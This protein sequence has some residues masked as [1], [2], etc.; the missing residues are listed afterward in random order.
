LKNKDI[1]IIQARLSSSRVNQ[2]MINKIDDN[3]IIEWVIRRLSYINCLKIVCLPFNDIDSKLHK[4]ISKYL[5]KNLL[6]DFG[7]QENVYLRVLD[8]LSRKNIDID[9][10]LIRV[11]A[12]RPFI[13]PILVKNLSDS[14]N[15]KNSLLFNHISYKEFF[16]PRGFGAEIFSYRLFKELYSNNI[17][18]YHKE[19]MTSLIWD[20]E[21]IKKNHKFPE[22][23]IFKKYINL[24]TD[25]DVDTIEDLE[26]IKKLIVKHSLSF[27]NSFLYEKAIR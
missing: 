8:I 1:I 25:Y 7:E 23:Y 22:Q 26:K 27:K 6:I 12:D 21:T 11:C 14:F 10:N 16:I 3:T 13:E 19:H 2:K 20:N 9:S 24:N 18:D 15:D 17:S 4:I 5:S